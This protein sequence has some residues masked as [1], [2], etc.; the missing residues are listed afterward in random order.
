MKQLLAN[1]E[2]HEGVTRDPTRSHWG[3][4]QNYFAFLKLETQVESAYLMTGD[5]NE[6]RRTASRLV[7][8]LLVRG[9]YGDAQS[10]FDAVDVKDPNGSVWTEAIPCF[11][12]WIQ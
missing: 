9:Q 6:F 7:S 12:D 5:V 3:I 10:N 4:A 8:A 11:F 2:R 1:V